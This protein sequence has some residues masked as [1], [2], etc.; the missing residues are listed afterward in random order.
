MTRMSC[1]KAIRA[2]AIQGR[3]EYDT[4]RMSRMM[5]VLVVRMVIGSWDMHVGT[6]VGLNI[7]IRPSWWIDRL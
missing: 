4:I 7:T 5:M 3:L 2:L 1:L 6:P